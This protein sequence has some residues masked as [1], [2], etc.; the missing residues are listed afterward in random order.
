MS[1]IT[2]LAGLLDLVRARIMAGLTD[3]DAASRLPVLATRDAQGWPSARS[4]VLRGFDAGDW[5][6]DVHSDADAAKVLQLTDGPRAMLQFWDAEASLQVRM[7]A[8]VIRLPHEQEKALWEQVPEAARSQYG[9][10]PPPGTPIAAADA[11][12]PN[13]RPARFAVLRARILRIEALHIG[14]IHRRARFEREE[15]W[16]GSWLVP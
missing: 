15:G 8:H 3:K 1:D 11:W 4:M 2:T 12:H 5:T 9:T 6:L 16:Q 13:P 14:D 10:V 7:R